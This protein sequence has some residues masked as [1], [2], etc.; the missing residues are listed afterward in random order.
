LCGH[1]DQTPQDQAQMREREK[2]Y[3]SQYGLTPRYE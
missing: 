3:L 2:A 1:D